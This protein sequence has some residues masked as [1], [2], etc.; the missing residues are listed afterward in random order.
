MDFT[1]LSTNDF[2]GL[3]LA[4]FVIGFVFTGFLYGFKYIIFI[5]LKK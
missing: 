3:L 1:N 5:F 4:F 2:V